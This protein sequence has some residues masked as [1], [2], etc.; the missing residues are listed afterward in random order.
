MSRRE[1]AQERRAARE[2]AKLNAEAEKKKRNS[3]QVQITKYRCVWLRYTARC[4]NK[5]DCLSDQCTYQLT[6]W[7]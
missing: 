6:S 7:S 1:V 3:N 4:L 5:A 2:Q